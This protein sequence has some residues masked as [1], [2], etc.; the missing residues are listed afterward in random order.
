MKP[1]KVRKLETCVSGR[2]LLTREIQT[3]LGT[4][5]SANGLDVRLEPH[6]THGLL[7]D[8]IEN[9]QEPGIVLVP[10]RFTVWCSGLV[11]CCAST[12]FDLKLLSREVGQFVETQLEHEILV[13]AGS[14]N[15]L[16]VLLE[17]SKT[18]GL[19]ITVDFLEPGLELVLHRSVIRL[20]SFVPCRHQPRITWHVNILALKFAIPGG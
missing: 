16:D 15:G 13:A 1:T 19:L 3:I 7:V 9:F 8:I 2:K 4:I 20:K 5:G 17:N 18:H 11:P 10:H 12:L 6:E 14:A